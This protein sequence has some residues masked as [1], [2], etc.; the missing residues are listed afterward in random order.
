M[1][2]EKRINRENDLLGNGDKDNLFL[3]SSRLSKL[4]QHY[5]FYK[6][7]FR[8]D[9]SGDKKFRSSQEF[10]RERK[11]SEFK[12][13]RK[14]LSKPKHF[15]KFKSWVKNKYR[16]KYYNLSVKQTDNNM[17]LVVS[18]LRKRLLFYTS[19]GRT[20]LRCSRKYTPY[21]AELAGVRVGKFLKE[22]R[23]RCVKVFLHYFPTDLVYAFFKGLTKQKI[24]VLKVVA[25]VRRSHN[26]LRSPKKARKR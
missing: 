22:R 18:T 15:Y 12:Q 3:K 1:K 14:F 16:R 7:G 5:D 9:R 26:G 21:G 10:R 8:N 2:K 24:R 19:L 20:G 23:V 4:K 13:D 6:P 17:F 25:A 11:E